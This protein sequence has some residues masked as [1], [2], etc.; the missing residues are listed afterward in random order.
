MEVTRRKPLGVEL[1]SRGLVTEDDIDKALDY[2]KDHP[3]Q[4]IGDIIY[5]LD[6]CDPEILIKNMG[7]I[8]GTKGILLTK[9]KIKVKLTDYIS[10]EMAKINKVIPFEVVGDQIKVCFANT[11]NDNEMESIRILLQSKGLHM[12]SYITFESII[13]KY[14]KII[15]REM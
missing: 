8:L 15:E 12:D 10:L 4:K 2:Q 7:E 1:V 14:L 3:N 13:D 11:M 9:E 5:T 6:L